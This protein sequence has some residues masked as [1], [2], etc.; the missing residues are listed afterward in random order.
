MRDGSGPRAASA[1]VGLAP[2]PGRRTG[3]VHHTGEEW[4]HVRS[5]AVVLLLGDEEIALNGGDSVRFDSGSTHRL[6]NT[7]AR[8]ARVLICS[9][10]SAVHHPVSGSD[11]P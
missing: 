7:S 9:T 3:A 5:G 10:A 11:H 2:P 1:V 6:H 8:A 4:L